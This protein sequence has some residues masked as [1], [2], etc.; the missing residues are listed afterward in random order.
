MKFTRGCDLPLSLTPYKVACVLWH[1]STTCVVVVLAKLMALAVAVDSP[2]V[3]RAT[4]DIYSI[5]YAEVNESLSKVVERL[6][7]SGLN[8]KYL[9]IAVADSSANRL[10]TQ[11][12]LYKSA[13]VN[14]W[15]L[16]E[17]VAASLCG[18]LEEC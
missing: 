6:S 15:I 14:Q 10:A 13:V 17:E 16:A 11:L 3:C 9:A 5:V 7:C 4:N 12:I 18:L 8:N 2:A 1:L